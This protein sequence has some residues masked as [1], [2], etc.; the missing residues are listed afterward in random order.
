MANGR[1]IFT[2]EQ[3]LSMNNSP[4]INGAITEDQL[5]DPDIAN[6][7]LLGRLIE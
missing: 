5:I 2:R 1:C 3:F 7:Q 6:L 4:L